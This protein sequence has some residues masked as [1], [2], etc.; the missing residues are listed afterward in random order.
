MATDFDYVDAKFNKWRQCEKV[1]TYAG[2]T[3]NAIGDFDGTGD[4]FDI[5]TVTGTVVVKVFA[6]CE[7]TLTIDATATKEVGTAISTAGIIAQTA[8]D[9][10]DVNEIW[11]D[12][13]PD[14]SV[15]AAS[16]VA[17]NIV[18]QDIISTTA[19]ANIK[20]GVLRFICLWKP[21]SKDGN[22]VAA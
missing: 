13:A 9:A 12:A 15:E 18:N 7:T 20:T 6:L 8:G 17:E 19:T 22:V 5:F 10:A 3:P 2:A 14:S 4:P 16:V 1:I 11:H 21:V